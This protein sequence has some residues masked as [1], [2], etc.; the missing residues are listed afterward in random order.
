MKIWKGPS[1]VSFHSVCRN[2]RFCINVKRNSTTM[3][4]PHTP[5]CSKYQ[6]SSLKAALSHVTSPKEP[7][8]VYKIST[9]TGHTREQDTKRTHELRHESTMDEMESTRTCRALTP[10]QETK[11]E[12]HRQTH[13]STHAAWTG[14]G[15]RHD[16]QPPP[17]P[18]TTIGTTFNYYT[19]KQFLERP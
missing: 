17:R 2:C 4:D 14:H 5:S 11:T 18:H 10:A 13:A 8:R 15:S 7:S 6:V 9:Q 3:Q 16:S 1:P 12:N 19:R